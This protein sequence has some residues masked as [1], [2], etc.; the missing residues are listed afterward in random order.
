MS[1]ANEESLCVHPS[2]ANKFAC[3]FLQVKPVPVGVLSE[4]RKEARGVTEKGLKQTT[5]LG[6]E[7]KIRR[8]RSSQSTRNGLADDKHIL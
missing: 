1:S 8:W 5:G 7:T 6:E 4:N 2:K 3:K